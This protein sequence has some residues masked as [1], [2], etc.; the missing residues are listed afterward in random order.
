MYQSM[1]YF[2]RFTLLYGHFKSVDKQN[3][4]FY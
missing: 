1:I 2:F 4:D 3:K